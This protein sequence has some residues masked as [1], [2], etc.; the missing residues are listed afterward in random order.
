MSEHIALL[1]W[2]RGDAAF[3]YKSY[4]RNHSWD[5]G[6][7]TKI[8]ASAAADYLGDETCVDPEQA[9]VA[10][11]SSCH[12][13]TFLAIAAMSKLTVDSYSDRSVGHLGKNAAGKSVITRV[14]LYPQ[15]KF[16]DGAAPST[17]TLQRLHEKA[18]RECFLAN[19]V[20]CEIVTHLPDAQVTPDPEPG[21]QTKCPTS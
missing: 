3:N 16:A 13:L 8:A 17:E 14:D 18:H 11:L 19:S 1:N 12:M 20:T 6:Q 7:G 21:T 4:S 5:F 9:F 2:N 10:A 15:I